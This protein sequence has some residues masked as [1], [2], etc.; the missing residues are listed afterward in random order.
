MA[1]TKVCARS[2]GE[3]NAYEADE[4]ALDRRTEIPGLI[5]CLLISLIRAGAKDAPDARANYDNWA[6]GI[7]NAKKAVFPNAGHLVNIDM[8]KEFN[9]A[10]L[11]FLSKL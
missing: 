8:P 11:E 3:R 5:S 9:Q 1:Y 7:P 4:S 10:V 2:A 6:K